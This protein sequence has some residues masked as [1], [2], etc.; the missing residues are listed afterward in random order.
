MALEYEM[1]QGKANRVLPRERTG[2]NKPIV[3]S[4][5]LTRDQALSHWNWSTDAKTLYNQIIH[6]TAVASAKLLQPCL[7]L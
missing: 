6:H 3:E 5:L 1:K 7:T 2:H 4:L